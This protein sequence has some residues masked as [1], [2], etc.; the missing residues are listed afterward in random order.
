[1]APAGYMTTTAIEAALRRLNDFY[2]RVTQLIELPEG[3][4]AAH[5]RIH[6]LRI[7]SGDDERNGVLLIAGPIRTN[8]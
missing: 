3:S 8:S 1:M 7:R 6:A 2:P 4:G 5:R